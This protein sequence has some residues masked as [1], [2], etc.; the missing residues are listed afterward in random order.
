VEQAQILLTPKYQNLKL[1]AADKGL[2]IAREF[3]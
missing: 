1:E 2:L 3:A